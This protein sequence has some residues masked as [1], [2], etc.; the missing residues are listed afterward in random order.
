MGA[1]DDGGGGLGQLIS[2]LLHLLKRGCTQN[3]GYSLWDFQLHEATDTPACGY[4][5]VC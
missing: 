5:E 2:V 1:V 4:W 3:C